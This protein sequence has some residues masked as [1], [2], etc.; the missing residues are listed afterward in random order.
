MFFN[1]REDSVETIVPANL[2]HA[3]WNELDYLAGYQQQDA[4][5]FLIAFLDGLDQHLKLNHASATS[6]P[7][8]L[9]VNIPPSPVMSGVEISPSASVRKSPRSDGKQRCLGHG[10]QTPTPLRRSFSENDPSSVGSVLIIPRI[11]EVLQV[12]WSV[13]AFLVAWL[14]CENLS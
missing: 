3:V 14:R 6:K 11:A 10:G 5:E 2:L 12:R 13:F 4:H 1:C 9:S 7:L 8:G